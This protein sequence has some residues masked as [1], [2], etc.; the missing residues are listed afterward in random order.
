MKCCCNRD[1]SRFPLLH[2]SV[3]FCSIVAMYCCDL[4]H[5]GVSVSA[6]YCCVIPVVV[7]CCLCRV[8]GPVPGTGTVS[9]STRGA[10]L[11]RDVHFE[12]L[13]NSRILPV[14]MVLPPGTFSLGAEKYPVLYMDR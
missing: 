1:V 3:Q 14:K 7:D 12:F 11:L 5:C 9:A 10:S 8:L 6:F 4:Y 2:L 13:L